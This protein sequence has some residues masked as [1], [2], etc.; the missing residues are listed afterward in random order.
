MYTSFIKIKIEIP[1]TIKRRNAFLHY[2]KKRFPLFG[3]E[4]G[5]NSSYQKVLVFRSEPE[6][7]SG[8]EESY[9]LLVKQFEMLARSFTDKVLFYNCRMKAYL[10][11]YNRRYLRKLSDIHTYYR[12]STHHYIKK[13]GFRPDYDAFLRHAYE[14]KTY[15]PEYHAIGSEFCFCCIHKN[16]LFKHPESG[17]T[18]FHIGREE[19]EYGYEPKYSLGEIVDYDGQIAIIMYTP[20]KMSLDRLTISDPYYQ[21]DYLCD[22]SYHLHHACI[23]EYTLKPYRGNIPEFMELLRKAVLQKDGYWLDNDNCYSFYEATYFHNVIDEFDKIKDELIDIV[24]R[25]PE[26]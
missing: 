26:S 9:D 20:N 14:L 17:Y 5:Y 1:E 22:N 21:I 12:C 19:L 15:Y 13:H 2:M 24:S 8:D 7:F 11:I 18:E 6:D 4:N 3:I 10:V 23:L 16:D 25:K